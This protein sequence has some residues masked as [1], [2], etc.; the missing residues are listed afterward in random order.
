MK[1]C[2]LPEYTISR[3]DYDDYAAVFT[4]VVTEFTIFKC[5]GNVSLK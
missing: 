2:Q 4:T 3:S 5:P 1:A